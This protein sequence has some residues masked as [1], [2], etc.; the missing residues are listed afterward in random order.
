MA[1]RPTTC[2]GEGRELR[3]GRGRELEVGLWWPARIGN[4]SG[5]GLSLL[6]SVMVKLDRYGLVYM[7]GRES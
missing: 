4:V 6:L 5:E 3:G 7:L 1:G 2:C